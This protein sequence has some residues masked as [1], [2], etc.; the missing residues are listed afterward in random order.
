MQ[1]STLIEGLDGGV[2]AFGSSTC[3]H[4]RTQHS[5]PL[6]LEHWTHKDNSTFLHLGFP[7]LQNCDKVNFCY[8]K[9]SGL[10]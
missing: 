10:S 4:M 3:Y 9:V 6:V 2:Q 1:F 7:S 8:F 5:S